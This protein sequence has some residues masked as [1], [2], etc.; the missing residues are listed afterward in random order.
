IYMKSNNRRKLMSARPQPANDVAGAELA[1]EI[2]R[3]FNAPRRLVYAA[4]TDQ[5]HSTKWAPHNMQIIHVEADLRV[6]GKIRVGMRG[7]DGVEH[8]ESG[9]YR[10]IVANERLVFTH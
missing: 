3:V 8:W 1:L 6:G 10:E 9:A 7:V 4:W 5:A 2:E